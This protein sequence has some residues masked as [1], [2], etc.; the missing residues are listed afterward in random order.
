MG[1][2][3]DT[4]KLTPMVHFFIKSADHRA[5]GQTADIMLKFAAVNRTRY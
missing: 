5:R 2:S 3:F 4:V 1:V